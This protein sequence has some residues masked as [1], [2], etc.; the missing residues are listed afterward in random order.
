MGREVGIVNRWVTYKA[1][2]LL[3]YDGPKEKSTQKSKGGP[4]H[5]RAPKPGPNLN[6][7]GALAGSHIDHKFE[8]GSKGGATS[9]EA[10]GDQSQM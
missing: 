2:H 6:S 1:D 9:E 7:Q 3:N 10:I 4:Q 8:D 5:S